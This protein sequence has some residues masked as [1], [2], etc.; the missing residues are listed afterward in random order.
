MQEWID[1]TIQMG[2]LE[3]DV[4]DVKMASEDQI[5][6]DAVA[7]RVTMMMGHTGRYF[8]TKRADSPLYQSKHL[9]LTLLQG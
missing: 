7:L 4:S 2:I 9:L 8:E 3:R 6:R 1:A 5:T